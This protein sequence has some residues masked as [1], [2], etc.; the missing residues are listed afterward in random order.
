MGLYDDIRPDELAADLRRFA[1][2][3]LR[4]DSEGRLLEAAPNLLRILGDLRAKIFA[5][6]VRATGRLAARAEE[7]E[8][9]REARRVIED[10]IRRA[11]EAQSEWGRPWSPET[12]GE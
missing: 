12:E 8:D 7:P 9:V 6:E 4:L 2:L 11:R 5:Y 3:L 10:A 1:E